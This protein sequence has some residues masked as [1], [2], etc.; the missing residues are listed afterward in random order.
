MYIIG[1][2]LFCNI[3]ALSEG[4]PS[5]Q[6]DGMSV[7]GFHRA[8]NVNMFNFRFGAHAVKVQLES[9]QYRSLAPIR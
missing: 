2:F 8:L 3:Q 7:G 1:R 4:V 9:Y 6:A 5:G